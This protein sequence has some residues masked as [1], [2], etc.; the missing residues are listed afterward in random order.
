[1]IIHAFDK[2]ILYFFHIRARIHLLHCISQI[3]RTIISVKLRSCGSVCFV[4]IEAAEIS[5]K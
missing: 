1:M 3:F 5:I 2:T 4:T